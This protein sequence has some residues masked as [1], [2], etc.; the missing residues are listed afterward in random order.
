MSV[1]YA[2]LSR[3]RYIMRWGLM[4]NVRTENVMEH[5]AMVAMLA[6]G[7]AVLRNKNGGNVNAD[8]VGMI[9]LFHET[10]EVITGDLPTPI[11]Y[12]NP[13]ITEAY[14]H[15]EKQSER[16]LIS[17]LPEPLEPELKS[18]ISE[19]TEEEQKLVKYADT[20]AAYIKCIEEISEGNNEFKEAEQY[21]L[22]KLKDYNSEE[23]NYF[24][25]N[26]VPYFGKSL[27]ELSHVLYKK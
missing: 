2:F 12:A 20:L 17:T 5:S 3:M 10:G 25:E 26:I 27:D 16:L 19:C 23:V 4:R 13:S 9:A 1:F 21:T 7:L 8:R 11:K 6:Q 22:K 24:L 15:L 18:L 14:K